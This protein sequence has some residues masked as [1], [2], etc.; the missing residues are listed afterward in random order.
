[1]LPVH[2][3]D[4]NGG[5]VHNELNKGAEVDGECMGNRTVASRIRKASHGKP[6]CR[7]RRKTD[8]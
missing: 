1:M 7:H 8:F 3:L 4:N 5:Q 6:L 2:D